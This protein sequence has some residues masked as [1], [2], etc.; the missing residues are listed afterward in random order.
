LKRLD[1]GFRRNDEKC[2]F[3]TFY[4]AVNIGALYLGAFQQPVRIGG[5]SGTL[6]GH[7]GA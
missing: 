7:F 1:S 3:S 5:L 6:Q 2:S 4:E